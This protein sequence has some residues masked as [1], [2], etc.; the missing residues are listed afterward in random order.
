MLGA[1]IGFLLLLLVAGFIFWAVQQLLALVPMAEPFATIIRIVLYAI[2]LLIVIYAIVTLL[3][4]AGVVV[5][6]ASMLR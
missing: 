1:L 5:P 2:V 4:F 3:G 6:H